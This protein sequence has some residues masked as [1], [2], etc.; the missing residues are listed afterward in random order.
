VQRDQFMELYDIAVTA[1]ATSRDREAL[2]DAIAAVTRIAAWCDS[3][4][5]A[6]AQALDKMGAVPEDVMAKA[7]RC[8]PRDAERIVKRADTA[9]KAPGVW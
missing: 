3:Q 9:N 1:D 6:Y 7:S 8:D 4:Q 5:I 2:I